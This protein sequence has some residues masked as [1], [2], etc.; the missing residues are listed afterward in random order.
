METPEKIEAA[1]EES[2]WS[3][4][5]FVVIFMGSIILLLTANAMAH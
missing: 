1:E 2:R 3:V 5:F 4:I